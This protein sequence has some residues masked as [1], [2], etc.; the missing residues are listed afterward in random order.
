[1]ELA[2]EDKAHAQRAALAWFEAVALEPLGNGHIHQTYLLHSDSSPQERFVLQKINGQVYGDIPALM[3]QTLGVLKVLSANTHYCANYR[4]P[5]LVSTRG[6]EPFC[7]ITDNG[8]HQAWRLWRFVEDSM[9][10]DP[11]SNRQQI[12]AAAKAFGG[13]QSAIAALDP[14][15]LVETIPGFLNM[16]HYLRAF[17]MA[18]AQSKA[19]EIEVAS[20]WIALVQRNRQW[21]KSLLESN[22]V[23]HG[24]CKI[25]NLLFDRL[26]ASVLSVIDLDNNMVGHW[27]WDFGDLARSVAFSRGG[28]DGL[29]YQACLEGFLQGRGEK[30]SGDN[31]LVEHLAEAPGFLAFMLGLR[32]LTDHLSGD[33]YFK[34]ASHGDNLQ[35]AIEQFELFAQFQSNQEIMRKGAQQ[36]L[37]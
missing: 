34:V 28:F 29:D 33:R 4:V 25:N 6:G 2:S 23:I 37:G 22:A 31:S 18:V 3:S 36:L 19:S 32:F 26:G 35:R 21:P 14:M 1:M 16:T 15:G 10:C 17:D 11:P 8:E 24:D 20:P 13:Y 30:F 9:T 12:R 5:E 7:V 27:A